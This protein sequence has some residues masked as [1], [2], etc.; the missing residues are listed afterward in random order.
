MKTKC[1][2]IIAGL[3]ILPLALWAETQTA[4]SCSLADVITAY[5]AASAGDVVL[6]PSGS[7]TWSSTFTIDKE[8]SLVGAGPSFTRIEID[9]GIP[10]G[11]VI[12]LDNDVPVRVTGI[13]F[14]FSTNN[15]GGASIYI[16]GKKDGSFPLTKVRIDHN[17]FEKGTR[18]V[19]VGGWVES[20][21][22]H[23]EFVNSNIGVGINGDNNYSWSRP[24][25]AGTANSLFIEDNTFTINNNADREPAQQIYHQEGGRTVIRYNTFDGTDYTAGNSLWIDSHGTQN[26]YQGD[27]F[28]FRGQPIIEIYENTFDCHKTYNLTVI[29]GGS[30]LVYNNTFTQISGVSDVFRLQ[31]EE[32]WSSHFA[33]NFRTEWPAEDQVTNSFFWDNTYKGSPV[34]IN[35]SPADAVFIQID[36]DFFRH[37]PQ[38]SGGKSYYP[39]RQGADDMIFSP[40]GANAY[41][42]YTP[43]VY[44]H[45]LQ[46]SFPNPQQQPQA[47]ANLRIK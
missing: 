12:D 35:V 42:P 47:P 16:R 39:T 1:S 2:R 37:A 45:P 5:N 46:E 30:V 33:G 25:A 4:A 44:P 27:R 14:K 8:I 20:L 17:K 7:E 19:A 32:A 28:D 11:I 29:R 43:Y 36:R 22:D 41:F 15:T 3:F 40:A 23:N 13:H 9:S 38:A 6:I 31:E 34:T 18:A 10:A 26:Y 21:I 24:I